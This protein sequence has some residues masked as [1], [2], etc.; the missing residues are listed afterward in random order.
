[1]DGEPVRRRL[2]CYGS[3]VGAVCGGLAQCMCAVRQ[4][5]GAGGGVYG[6]YCI[7]VR[8]GVGRSW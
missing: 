2:R 5:A 4:G 8:A 3:V 7:V 6:S 1:M